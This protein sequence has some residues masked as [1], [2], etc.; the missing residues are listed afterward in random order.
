MPAVSKSQQRLFGQ[1]HAFKKGKLRR[2]S[3]QIERIAKGISDEDS[4]HFAKTEHGD[5]P[6]KTACYR[7]GWMAG[8][9]KLANG[10][11]TPASR[12]FVDGLKRRAQ[13]TG[14]N[15]LSTGPRMAIKSLATVRNPPAPVQVAPPQ[16]QVPG[17]TPQAQAPGAPPQVQTP[18]APQPLASPVAVSG[19]PAAGGIKVAG[20]AP[21]PQNPFLAMVA[22][23]IAAA[24]RRPAPRMSPGKKDV[25]TRGEAGGISLGGKG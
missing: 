10:G 13:E 6:E 19:P 25:P 22:E 3:P 8:R 24:K 5:L 14:K 20:A 9:V 11:S 2:A 21:V 4:L 18:G 16:A 1:V 17:A 7:V 23:R 12:T 15:P